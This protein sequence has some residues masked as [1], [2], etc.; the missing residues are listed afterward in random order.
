[1]EIIKQQ[2]KLELARREFFYYCHL[3]A[4]EFYKEDRQY[5][6]DLCNDMQSFYESNETDNKEKK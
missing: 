3:K 5:L 1:M 4:P 2:A 6:I